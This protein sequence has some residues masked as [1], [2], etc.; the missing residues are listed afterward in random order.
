MGNANGKQTDF[1]YSIT[2][3]ITLKRGII[4]MKR[5]QLFIDGEWRDPISNE[6]VPNV[7]PANTQDVIG[8]FAFAGADDINLAAEAAAQAFPGWRSTPMVKRG[9]ILYKAANLLEA[10]L[11]E[12]AQAMTR[13]E[14]KTL[15]EA[16]GETAR[17]V[18][19]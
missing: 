12:V 18:A 5:Y 15:I 6:W 2:G 4:E 13:E 16:R 7:N 3:R 19:I 14:G 8:E 10:R 17:G 9:D 1:Q 11:E